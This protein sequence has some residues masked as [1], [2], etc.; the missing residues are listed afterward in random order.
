MNTRNRNV[1][2][3]LLIDNGLL[4]EVTASYTE[5]DSKSRPQWL[6]PIYPDYALAVSPLLVDLEVAYKAG[7]IDLVMGYVNARNPALHVSIIETEMNLEQIAQHLRRFIFIVAPDDKQ[8]TLRYADCTVLASLSTI[9]TT[10]QW[11]AMK[12]PISRWEI[13]DRSGT[14]IQL[15]SVELVENTPTPFCLD[16]GQFAAL[17]EAS[18]P[19]HCIAKV[20]M[21]RKG[22]PLPGNTVEQ[23]AWALAARQAWRATGN[24]SS[25]SLL[26]LTE[27]TLITRGAVLRRNE[28]ENLL[29]MDEA[30]AFREK[31]QELIKEMAEW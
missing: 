28:I 14:L 18:E 21:M 24:S 20:K 31:L 26:F 17:D 12:G 1:S 30:N 6:T 7:D 22:M 11:A 19:D 23:H 10:A 27:S 2:V 29:A 3:Y 25:M 9:L 8:F 15:P 5:V 13:H 4:E 16:L